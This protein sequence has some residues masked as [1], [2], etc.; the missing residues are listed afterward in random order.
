MFKMAKDQDMLTNM[1]RVLRSNAELL[2]SA[3]EEA[4]RRRRR[5]ADVEVE[6]SGLERVGPRPVVS[7]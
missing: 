6:E 5:A 1:A 7:Q 2:D 4:L 3:E